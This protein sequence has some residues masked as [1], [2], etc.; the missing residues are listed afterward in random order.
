MFARAFLR[1]GCANTP[2]ILKLKLYVA[3]VDGFAQGGEW[4]A[5]GDEL[6]CDVASVVGRGD[7]A[8]DSVPLYFLSAIKFMA[9]W[10]APGVEVAEPVNIFLNRADQ[11]AFHDLHVIDVVEKLDPRGVDRLNHLKAPGGVVA[12]VIFVIDFAVEQL[13]ADVD[14]VIFGDFLEAIEA[15]N[16]VFSA[17]FVRHARA[18]SRKRD[19]VGHA[20]FSGDGDIFAKSFFDL[21]LIFDAVLSM[22]NISTSRVAHAANQAIAPRDFPLI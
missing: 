17:L 19:D 20:G 5:C 13:E 11:V 18:I 4:I 10:N 2:T 9:M 14:A 6:V 22:R 21:G 3:E 7:A 15:S 12:H 1:N 8:H 16:G